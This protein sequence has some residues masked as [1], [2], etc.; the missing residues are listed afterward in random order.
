MSFKHSIGGGYPACV[1]SV[2]N[3]VV[4]WVKHQVNVLVTGVCVGN[5]IIVVK[6]LKPVETQVT[7]TGEVCCLSHSDG[8]VAS[9]S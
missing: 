7:R 8:E 4:C 2:V 1:H 5:Q 6:P 9:Y 3:I